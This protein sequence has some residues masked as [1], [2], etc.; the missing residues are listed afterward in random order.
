MIFLGGGFWLAGSLIPSGINCSISKK[1]SDLAYERTKEFA[2][3]SLQWRV[4]DAKKAGITPLAALGFGGV[5][6]FSEPNIVGCDWI[7]NALRV[8]DQSVGDLISRST[9]RDNDVYSNRTI[10]G[11]LKM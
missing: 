7:G 2:Q 11:L 3:D 6:D 4:Q 8:L 10:N 1:Q 5:S 9:E